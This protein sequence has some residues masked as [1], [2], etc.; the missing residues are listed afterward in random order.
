M[1]IKPS[2]FLM[3]EA[4]ASPGGGAPIVPAVSPAS[5]ATPEAPKFLTE[6]KLDEKLKAFQNGFFANAR[7]AG[8]LKQDP[9]PAPTPAPQTGQPENPMAVLALRDAFDDAS[10]EMKLTK[11]QRS[12]LR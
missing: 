3:S 2:K 4:D 5:I 1:F 7:K 12:L 9:E 6:D 11:G 10:S 8:L